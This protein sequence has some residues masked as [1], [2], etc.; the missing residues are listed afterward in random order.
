M[1]QEYRTQWGEG[2]F[3]FLFVQLAPF[4]RHKP[5]ANSAPVIPTEP[6]EDSGWALVRESQL[7][8]SLT[9]PNTAMA[10]I[11]DYGDMN[12]I[13]PHQKE[14]VALRLALAAQKLAYGKDIPYSGPVYKS[15]QIDANC[16]TLTF[17]H[18]EG[19]L[20]AKDGRLGGFTI[21]GDDRKFVNAEAVI[22]GERVI[23]CSPKIAHPA[24]VR[25]CWSDYP[26]ASLFN[27]AGLPASPF[28]T[29]NW[30]VADGM[31]YS[32]KSKYGERLK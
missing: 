23:V 20:A 21:A 8:T 28:R 30:P 18:V 24:A 32:T 11:T 27:K 14:P 25:Y 19:G 29:D 15:M 16:I 4:W 10:V 3:P 12:D 2:D 13:H 6:Q 5:D 17:D 26:V 7:L 1:I 22:K 31:E 9:V